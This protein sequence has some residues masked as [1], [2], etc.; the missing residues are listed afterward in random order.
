MDEYVSMSIVVGVIS[1][2]FVIAIGILD[3]ARRTT[4][5]FVLVLYL[6]IT[7][8]IGAS[9][10]LGVPLALIGAI[11]WGHQFSQPFPLLVFCF[12]ICIPGFFIGLSLTCFALYKIPKWIVMRDESKKIVSVDQSEDE[13]LDAIIRTVRE[14]VNSNH[15]K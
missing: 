15:N 10:I 14:Q 5:E 1:A 11:L 3:G 8:S 9:F 7:Q 4:S 12:Y 6:P 2:L 13:D